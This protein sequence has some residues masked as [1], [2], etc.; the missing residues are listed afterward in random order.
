MYSTLEGI[1]VQKWHN[2]QH[3][4]ALAEVFYTDDNDNAVVQSEFHATF[5][6]T[7]AMYMSSRLTLDTFSLDDVDRDRERGKNGETDGQRNAS[8]HADVKTFMRI[9]TWNNIDTT[10]SMH[11]ASKTICLRH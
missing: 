3:G 7:M 9:D 11:L 10:L 5:N 4:T 6:V 2:E 1:L 8:L